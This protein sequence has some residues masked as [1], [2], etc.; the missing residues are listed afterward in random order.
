MFNFSVFTFDFFPW[1]LLSEGNVRAEERN[2]NE[3]LFGNSKQFTHLF[4]SRTKTTSE[5]NGCVLW[6]VFF[7]LASRSEGE[8]KLKN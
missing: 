1:V 3:K 7:A 8:R 6:F 4:S 5:K 2:Y